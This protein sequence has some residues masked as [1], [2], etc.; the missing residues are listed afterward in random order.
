MDENKNLN[1]GQ[2][3]EN[4]VSPE[5]EAAAETAEN[6]EEASESAETSDNADKNAKKEMPRM[7]YKK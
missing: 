6:T 1:A 7:L 2:P 3:E 4:Q 5:E